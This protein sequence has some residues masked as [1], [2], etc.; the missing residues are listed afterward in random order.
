MFFSYYTYVSITSIIIVLLVLLFAF[1]GFRHGFLKKFLDLANSLCGFFFSI[2][3]CS[4][5]SNGVTYKYFGNTFTN[6]FLGNIRESEAYQ[7]FSNPQDFIHQLGVPSFIAKNIAGDF[8]VEATATL[9]ATN[10]SKVVCVI[11]SFLFLFIGTTII[12]FFLK[13]LVGALRTNKVVRVIDGTLGF[14]LYLILFYI[15]MCLVFLVVSLVVSANVSDTFNTIVIND[16]QLNSDKFR[17]AKY[18]YQNNIIGNFL[19]MFF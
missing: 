1:L 17:I 6:M 9:V 7:N 4:S 15:G 8:D 13:L 11:I 5:F 16:L 18:F 2:L 14:C 12:V 3:F 10:M 19:K